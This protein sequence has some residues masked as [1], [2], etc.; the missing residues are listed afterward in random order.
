MFVW[1][2]RAAGGI[3]GSGPSQA[4]GA[5]TSAA[6][7]PNEQRPVLLLLAGWVAGCALAGGGDLPK[8]VE[9]ITVAVTTPNPC[10]RIQIRSVHRRDDDLLVVSELLPPPPDVLCAQVISEAKE[11]L[12]IRTEPPVT[13]RHLV[14]GRTWSWGEAPEG[15]TFVGSEEELARHLEGATPLSGFKDSGRTDS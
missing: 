8:H 14:L 1:F 10:W 2:D 6:R 3:R 7:E 15:V 11:S 9:R 13:V 4:P 12:G 5:R